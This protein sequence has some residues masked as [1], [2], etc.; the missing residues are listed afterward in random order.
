M[1]ASRLLLLLAAVPA[2]AQEGGRDSGTEGKPLL[3][4][5]WARHPESGLVYNVAW[6]A[7]EPQYGLLA[8]R[9]LADFDGDAEKADAFLRANA[10][11]CLVVAFG[12]GAA[13]RAEKALPQAQVLRVG[14]EPGCAVSTRVDR[15]QLASLF[16][17]FRP[18]ARTIALF[19]P[20]EEIAGFTV[21]PCATPAEAAGCDLAW[22][23][24]GGEADPAALRRALEPLRI[25]LVSTAEA[26][27]EGTAAMLVRPDPGSL[28]R[29]VAAQAL[30]AIRDASGLRPVSVSRL[31]VTLDLTAARAAAHIV[32]FGALAR[33]DE[34]VRRP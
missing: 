17:L 19:G 10:D 15:A 29:A 26:T 34:I 5:R 22:L 25:P 33:A 24:E 13:R 27:P 3:F 21:K 30:R 16:R 8:R 28:G 18:G 31:R 6:M 23:S 4:V 11:A 2:L 12:E 7:L 1:R 9:R 32:P 20:A 14:V